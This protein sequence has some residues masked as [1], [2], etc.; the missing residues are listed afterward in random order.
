MSRRTPG[1]PLDQVMQVREPFSRKD[2]HKVGNGRTAEKTLTSAVKEAEAARNDARAVL[3]EMRGLARVMRDLNVETRARVRRAVW[4]V[5][6]CA[7][8]TVG[9]FLY[10]LARIGAL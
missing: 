6:A 3:D 5:A 9:S 10:A 2:G 4:T 7:A 1:K 8:A